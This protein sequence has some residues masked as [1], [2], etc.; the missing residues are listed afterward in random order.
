MKEKTTTVEMKLLDLKIEGL[1]NHFKI[2]NC[3][4]FVAFED[5]NLSITRS[6]TNKS[7]I[8][9]MEDYIM[10]V[11]KDL[12]TIETLQ[13]KDRILAKYQISKDFNKSI[14]E[15]NIEIDREKQILEQKN[16]KEAE[17]LKQEQQKET[18]TKEVQEPIIKEVARE[19]VQEKEYK[20]SFEVVGTIE[21]IK[22]LKNFM[23][24]NNIKFGSIK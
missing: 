13:N 24:Q 1:K 22:L 23:N 3:F 15:T 6:K 12:Q 4:S 21:Q 19:I 2:I 17:L 9:A 5:M 11:Q 20:A 18:E 7:I 16:A 10:Q 14:S 8:D